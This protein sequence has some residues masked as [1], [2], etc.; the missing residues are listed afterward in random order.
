MDPAL[1]VGA[2]YFVEGQYIAPDDAMAGNGLNN[3]SYRPVE[4]DQNR[5][6]DFPANAV[7]RCPWA[8]GTE[9]AYCEVP[10]IYAW[11]DLDPEVRIAVVDVPGEGRFHVGEKVFDNGDGT[12][13]YEYAIH[14]LNSDRSARAF[15]ADFPDSAT[16]TGAGFH[17]VPH[18]SGDCLPADPPVPGDANACGLVIANDVWTIQ[19]DEGAGSAAWFTDEFAIK[20]EANALRWG[21]MF[22]FWF[23]ADR[24]PSGMTLAITLFKPGDPS[25]VY[26]AIPLFGDDF[27]TGNTGRWD[28]TFQEP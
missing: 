21:T 9:P 19:V 2:S 28:D 24:P 22:N 15:T 12:W 26:F 16:I 13:R 14:N 17:H 8:N 18:H 1:N 25:I 10:A 4:V 20:P 7:N 6:L 23:D 11:A 3:A 5:N 27:E